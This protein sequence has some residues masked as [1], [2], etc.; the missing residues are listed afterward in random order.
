MCRKFTE[1]ELNRMNHDDKNAVICQLQDRLD[2]LEHDYE[3]LIEQIRL[4]DQQRYGRHTESLTAI[5]GQLSFFNEAEACCDEQHPEPTVDEVIDDAVKKPRKPKKKGQREE[6]LKDFPQEVIPHDISEAK[7]IGT[8][9]EGNYKS[10]PDEICW[11]LRF[12][13]AKWIAEKHIIKVYVGTDG[14][15]QDEF[16]RGD[17]PDTLFRGSIATASLEAA[18][19]NAKYVNS[20]PLDRVSRDF[21]ANGLNLSKQTISNWTVWCAERFLRP[22][23]DLMKIHQLEA[24]VNQCDETPLEVIHD[25]RPAG[26]KS[27][28]WVHLTGELS[29][30]PKIVVYEYQKTRH[31]DHP[32]E[33]YKEFNGILMTDGLEQY[34]KL[35]REQEGIVNANCL[36]HA[37][38]HFAN[39]IK[40]MGKGNQKAVES[41][42]AYKALVRIGAIYKL[43]ESLKTLSPE[44]R[45]KERQSSIRPLVEE[46]FAWIKEVL[47][48]GTVLPKSETSKGL[49]YS[50]NQEEYLKVFL[51]DGEVPI[52]DSA[53]ERALRNFTI[54]RKNWVTINTIR[55]AQASA[56]IY[57][58]TETAR[59]N[60]LNVYY[61]I[62][63]LL[64]ELPKLVDE[65]GNIGQSILD[66]LMPWS[67][68]LPADCYSKR[69]N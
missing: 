48:S 49:N 34:H 61:Y 2:K 14:L 28:M 29:P 22:V 13:P 8:F 24:H 16:L 3:N 31:S 7:L 35:A 65:N 25:G 15:H 67:K 43:E 41:S 39:A 33:Y 56:I 42:V 60:N 21:K 23:Y 38:R 44:E 4:A 45:L 6:D 17:Y 63:H 36:A 20:N 27:Y 47:A 57:S 68:S 62:K 12:E 58:I 64:T 5:A 59:A 46:Y 51:T 52:D 9:G 11:R 54:G 66:P 40:A 69:R 32:K 10:M 18:I 30:V 1:D 37:R 55:G 53:S 26:S 50:I 19:I